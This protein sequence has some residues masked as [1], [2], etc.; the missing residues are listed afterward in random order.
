MLL[1]DPSMA[2]KIVLTVDQLHAL[3]QEISDGKGS[4]GKLLK[5][6]ELYDHLNSTIGKLD[7]IATKL[8]NGEEFP[9]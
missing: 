6:Q 8:D 7:D 4:V 3:T 1:N 2:K 9:E 5:D